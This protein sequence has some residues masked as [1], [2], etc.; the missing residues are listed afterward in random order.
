[1]RGAVDVRP[2]RPRSVPPPGPFVAPVAA[3]AAGGLDLRALVP[4]VVA[5]DADQ[6][7]VRGER[8]PPHRVVGR[9]VPPRLEPDVARRAPR[10]VARTDGRRAEQPRCMRLRAEAAELAA[11]P[12]DDVVRV[13]PGEVS[14]GR[15]TDAA[16]LRED[17]H[18]GRE[19]VVER[20]PLGGR[21]V[22]GPVHV[23]VRDPEALQVGDVGGDG[24]GVPA[25][26]RLDVGGDGEAGR[27]RGA[28]D[29]A[30]PRVL[31]RAAPPPGHD[32]LVHAGRGDLP[33]LGGDDG[34]V[35]GGVEAARREERRR[36]ASRGAGVVL[37][38]VLPGAVAGGRAVPRVVEDRRPHRAAGPPVSPGDGRR[39]EE[40]AGECREQE[41]PH[42]G[43][44]LVERPAGA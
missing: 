24:H 23:H 37:L 12:D 10:V 13:D 29:R 19:G 8:R 32:D 38:P 9:T 33:H 17:P 21:T 39:A 36:D 43:R 41:G 27:A 2:R 34:P 22:F 16:G 30:E 5:R 11:R 35:A 28:G 18:G 6:V 20:G 31:E 40:H 44:S 7:A 3:P 1:M 42:A 25:R 26:V 15:K 14:G 4:L